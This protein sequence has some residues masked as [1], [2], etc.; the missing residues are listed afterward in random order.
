MPTQQYAS[1][2]VSSGGAIPPVRS[3]K[4]PLVAAASVI[5]LA[6]IGLGIAKVAGVFSAAP[7]ATTNTG[8]LAAPNTEA[9]NAPVLAPPP[10]AQPSAAP[11]LEGPTPPPA[12]TNPMP[13]DVIDYLRWLK[14]YEAG[15]QELK[16]Q[17]EAELMTIYSMAA[18][19]QLK[20]ALKTFDE[21]GNGASPGA[22]ADGGAQSMLNQTNGITQKWN[23]A[24][25]IFQQKTPPDPCASLASTYNQMLGLLVTEQTQILSAAQGALTTASK[26]D[27]GDNPEVKN[28]LQ[29]LMTEATTGNMS[30][31]EDQSIVDSESALN[32]VRSRYS[33]IPDDINQ[34][35]FNIQDQSNV[36]VPA[37]PTGI[38]F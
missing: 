19:N 31:R 2:P 13:Q 38:G 24:V 20:D 21:D 10:V 15:R 11:V 14:R 8:V 1:P 33:G 34:A 30:H 18:A 26:P 16:G 37:P 25:S 27:G 32:S 4:G 23:V 6:V 5:A 7:T 17:S 28:T 3:G 35:N 36:S 12:Q 29:A 22:N 9:V